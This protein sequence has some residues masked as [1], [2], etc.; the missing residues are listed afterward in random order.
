MRLRVFLDTCVLYPPLMRGFLLGMADRGLFDPLWSAGVV[1][2]WAH[3]LAARD[4]E[5]AAALPARL[6]R[7]AARWPAGEAGPGDPAALDLPDA[8]DRHV[9]AAAVAGGAA[10]LL[11]LNRRDFPA[12]RLAPWGLRA[13]HP[14]AFA[15]GLW[16]ADPAPVEAVLA[17][18]W[19]GLAG[20]KLRRALKT[21]G[22]PRLG[23]ALAG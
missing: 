1:R 3:L 16:L 21:A 20:P 8:G 13:E 22:L 15:L 23:K 9:L 17:E 12:R 5:A 7:M 6:A 18:V 4:P 11:T 19:P 14:D 2:E 10:V